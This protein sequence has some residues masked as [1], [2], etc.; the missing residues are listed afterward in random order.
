MEIHERKSE[1]LMEL[2]AKLATA[3]ETLET[4]KADC[5]HRDSSP[6]GDIAADGLAA[7]TSQSVRK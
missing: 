6:L 3:I 4:I 2:E 5:N 7:I 1:N